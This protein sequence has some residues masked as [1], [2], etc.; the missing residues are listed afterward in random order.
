MNPQ[1]NNIE[2]I[3]Q[4]LLGLIDQQ[5]AA[6]LQSLD[7]GRR[8][9]NAQTANQFNARGQLYSTGLATAQMRNLAGYL[10]QVSKI[11]QQATESQVSITQNVQDTI[12]RINEINKAAAELAGL[13]V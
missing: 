5:R 13:S 1:L 7:T 10:P 8:L 6:Q 11:N 3:M 4:T 9:E 12:N 2:Q